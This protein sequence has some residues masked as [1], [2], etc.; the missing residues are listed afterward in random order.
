MTSLADLFAVVRDARIEGRDVTDLL[1]QAGDAASW[2]DV[3]VMRWEDQ[4]A[5]RLLRGWV[6]VR[7]AKWYEPPADS[8]IPA[9]IPWSVVWVDEPLDP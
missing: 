6:T 4:P 9:G 5:Q 1:A 7:H 2:A 3:C 8:M